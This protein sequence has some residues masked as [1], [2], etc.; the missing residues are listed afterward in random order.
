M[1][2][3]RHKTH[4]QI[5][6]THS[7]ATIPRK[8][9]AGQ[10]DYDEAH[11]SFLL[12]DYVQRDNRQQVRRVCQNEGFVALVP[13]WAIWPF[14]ILVCSRRHFASMLFISSEEFLSLS[15]IFSCVTSTYW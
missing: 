4:C 7:V 15:D 6:E 9:L 3:S 13:F 14:E 2:A 10:A 11:N 5:G 1:G 8:E 12:C